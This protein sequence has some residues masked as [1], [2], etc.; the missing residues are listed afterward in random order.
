MITVIE[1]LSIIFE[2]VKNL[3][4]L[5]CSHQKKYLLKGCAAVQYLAD[6]G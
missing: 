2:E 3:K 6:L 4:C 1:H 5:K